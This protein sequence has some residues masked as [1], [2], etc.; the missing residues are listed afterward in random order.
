[1]E[2]SEAKKSRIKALTTE[3]MRYEINKGHRSRFQRDSF[4]YLK[5]CYHERVD[6]E[7]YEKQL[8][9]AKAVSSEIPQPATE[10]APT[11]SD[12]KHNP[13]FRISLKGIVEGVIIVILAA[14][15]IWLINHFF[16]LDLKP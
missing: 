4:D 1:M 5:T 10:S 3:E 15:I 13:R 14:C 7:Q 9:I 6:K 2:P 12:K 11:K 16:Y 8:K